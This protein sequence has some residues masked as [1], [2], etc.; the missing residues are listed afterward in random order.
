MHLSIQSRQLEKAISDAVKVERVFP[1]GKALHP[2]PTMNRYNTEC[3]LQ[4]GALT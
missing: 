1:N 4:M 2:G 3:I